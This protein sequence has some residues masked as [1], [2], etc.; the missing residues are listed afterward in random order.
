MWIKKDGLDKLKCHP[1]W[2][3]NILSLKTLKKRHHVTY[4]S[5][6]RDGAFKVHTTKGV[7]EFIPHESKFHYLD[8]NDHG[9]NE[10]A[11]VKTLWDNYEGYTKK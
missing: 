2:I 10:V 5:Q 1:K 11:L 8:L 3:A 4:D 7:V 6:D 9:E